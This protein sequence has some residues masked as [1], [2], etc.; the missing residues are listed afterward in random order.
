MTD[1]QQNTLHTPT[2]TGRGIILTLILNCGSLSAYLFDYT[3]IGKI[4]QNT[5]CSG[6]QINLLCYG[7]L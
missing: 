3:K 5:R 6:L 2:E 7:V 1:Y 4:S